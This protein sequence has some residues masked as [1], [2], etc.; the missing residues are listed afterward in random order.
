MLNM[1]KILPLLLLVAFTVVSCV[2]ARLHNEL[3]AKK[4]AC[5]KENEE[6][7]ASNL[8]LTT[9]QGEL[10]AMI[11]YLKNRINILQVAHLMYVWLHF[12]TQAIA[13]Y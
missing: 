13:A 5:D 2:P 4:S 1:K 9:R 6:L 7:K 11:D 3:K 8:N 10:S 12:L